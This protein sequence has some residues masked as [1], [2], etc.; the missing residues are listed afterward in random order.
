MLWQS[1]H[2]IVDETDRKFGVSWAFR[3]AE[4]F[5]PGP[6]TGWNALFD[7]WNSVRLLPVGIAFVARAPLRSPSMAVPIA[8]V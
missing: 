2:A 3:F 8:V 1:V 4:L 7:V 6:A 5:R